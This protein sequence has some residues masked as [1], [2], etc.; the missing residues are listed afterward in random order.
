LCSV[1]TKGV[2]GI[3]GDDD[4]KKRLERW[5]GWGIL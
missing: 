4:E 5:A 1:I 2:A 3:V